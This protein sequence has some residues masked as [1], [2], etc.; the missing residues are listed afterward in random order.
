M[1]RSIVQGTQ[2]PRALDRVIVGR[3][4][5]SQ[6]LALLEVNLYKK[7][8]HIFSIWIFVWAL[9]WL[10]SKLTSSAETHAWWR[11]LEWGQREDVNCGIEGSWKGCGSRAATGCSCSDGETE[12]SG[13]ELL[14]LETLKA[15]GSQP[16]SGHRNCCRDS[17]L[18]PQMMPTAGVSSKP[19]SLASIRG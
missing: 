14:E 17:K 13:P 6:P 10:L 12:Q 1:S 9:L 16:C 18:Q 4:F 5:Q 3:N 11:S 7:L 8:G 15:P 2:H 19:L